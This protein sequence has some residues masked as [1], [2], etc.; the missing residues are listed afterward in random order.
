MLTVALATGM[1]RG[2]VLGLRWDDVDL[3]A[4]QL[5]VRGTLKR[6]PKVGLVLDTPK[7]ASATR[8]IPLPDHAVAVLREHRRQQN[9]E[10]LAAGPEWQ[11]TG[12]VFTTPIGSPVDPRNLTRDLH[13]VS[14]AAGL[15]P[16][17]FHALRHTAATLMLTNGVP[18][19]VI[20]VTLGHASYAITADVYAKVGATLQR[21]AADVM[22]GLLAATGL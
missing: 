15:G 1:R 3:D 18:L 7:T 17:R 11:P 14:T 12:F 2:E 8:A 16:I 19:E 21:T 13:T 10:R 22:D 5:A 20:S 6:M 9:V 4:R